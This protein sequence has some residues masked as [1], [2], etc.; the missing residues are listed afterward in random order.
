MGR[1]GRPPP[2]EN[3]LATHPRKPAGVGDQI[4]AGKAR[5]RKRR[6]HLGDDGVGRAAV[7][8]H[9]DRLGKSLAGHIAQGRRQGGKG[10]LRLVQEDLAARP[11]RDGEGLGLILHG[12]SLGL[13]QLQ[14]HADGEQGGGDHEDD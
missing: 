7:G 4:D 3:R 1:P 8:P 11:H 14:G 6:H 5:L 2:S 13:G 12:G 10:N 9:I